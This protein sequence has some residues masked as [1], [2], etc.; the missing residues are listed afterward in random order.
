MFEIVQVLECSWDELL[1]KVKEAEDL[2][3]IIAAHQVFLDNITARCLLDE[4]SRV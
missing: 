1:T 4:Q 3:Y 2:D